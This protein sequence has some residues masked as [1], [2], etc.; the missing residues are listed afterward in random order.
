MHALFILYNILGELLTLWSFIF[1]SYYGEGDKWQHWFLLYIHNAHLQVMGVQWEN[2]GGTFSQY[3]N[4]I[5]RACG[6]KV[7]YMYLVVKK[8]PHFPFFKTPKTKLKLWKEKTKFW[9]KE[10]LKTKLK[11]WKEKTKICFK[12]TPRKNWNCE[13]KN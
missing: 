5:S 6:K 8:H 7:H 3:C 2:N 9:S 1:I 12:E 10:T 4:K 11:L 13:K